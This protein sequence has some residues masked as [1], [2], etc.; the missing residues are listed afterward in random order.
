MPVTGAAPRSWPAA[1]RA[2]APLGPTQIA[3]G[4]ALL[5]IASASRALRRRD[6]ALAVQLDDERLG[7]VPFGAGDG[8]RDVIGDDRVDQAAQLDDVDGRIASLRARP[9][10]HRQRAQQEPAEGDG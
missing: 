9:R 3:T 4:T 5:W 8:L 10:R 2:L 1:P 7:A 6:R